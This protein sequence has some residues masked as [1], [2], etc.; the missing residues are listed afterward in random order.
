MYKRK[1][2]KI[3]VYLAWKSAD[4]IVVLLTLVYFN[5]EFNIVQLI[6]TI[7]CYKFKYADFPANFYNPNYFINVIDN[8]Y[9]KE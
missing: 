3:S 7:G 5:C 4:Y 2:F 6:K 1:L 8:K 9:Y